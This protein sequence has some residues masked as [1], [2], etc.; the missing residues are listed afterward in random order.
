MIQ[1]ALRWLRVYRQQWRFTRWK[2]RR[3]VFVTGRVG[4][5][6]TITMTMR[7]SVTGEELAVLRSE[8]ILHVSDLYHAV[9]GSRLKCVRVGAVAGD[10]VTPP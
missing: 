10:G 1:A 8:L 4:P 5:G 7:A 6:D 2:L 3:R 9:S